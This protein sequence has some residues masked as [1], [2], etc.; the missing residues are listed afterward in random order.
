M[1]I[2]VKKIILLLF[3]GILYNCGV[4]QNYIIKYNELEPTKKQKLIIEETK[5]ENDMMLFFDG[6]FENDNLKIFIDKKEVYDGTISTDNTIGAAYSYTFSKSV[7]VIEIVLKEEHIKLDIKKDYPFINIDLIDN[8][9]VIEYRK[10]FKGY[11]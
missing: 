7:N 1:K 2:F 11:L 9:F 3:I 8:Q 10:T 6:G 5:K 4:S